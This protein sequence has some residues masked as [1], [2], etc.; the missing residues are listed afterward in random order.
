MEERTAVEEGKDVSGERETEAE[1]PLQKVQREFLTEPHSTEGERTPQA[2]QG[3]EKRLP[4]P[5]TRGAGST[6]NP[7]A[8]FFRNDRSEFARQAISCRFRI[9]YGLWAETNLGKLLSQH[10]FKG[11]QWD[12][13]GDFSSCRWAW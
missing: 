8:A 5:P 7:Q 11:W 9:A 10:K 3:A 2:T 1:Y 4:P 13:P 12:R 6:R